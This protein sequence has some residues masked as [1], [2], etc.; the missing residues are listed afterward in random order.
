[1]AKG[2]RR[3]CLWGLCLALICAAQ[4]WALADD[5]E[6]LKLL[7]GDWLGEGEMEA[8]GEDAQPVQIL[9]SFEEDGQFS[10]RFSSMDGTELY[11]Y[12]GTWAFE[13]VEGGM[14]RLRLRVTSTDNPRCAGST[15]DLECVYEFYSESWVENDTEHTWMIFEEQ[16]HSGQTPFEDVCGYDGTAVHRERGPNMRVANCKEFVSLREKRAAS[17]TR[18]AKVPLG[19]LV[20]A[21][22]ELGEENGFIL[23]VYHDT[24]GYILAEYLQT[25]E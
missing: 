11:S 14:D 10:L 8:E 15:Y 21:Y 3:V 4:S 23:C 6:L 12:A 16:A 22:P 7:P 18:L 1:M 24:Y 19:A 13:L 9:L 5:A 25:I 2:W 17:S 20:L